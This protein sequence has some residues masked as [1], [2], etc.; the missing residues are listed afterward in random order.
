MK[1]GILFLIAS[2]AICTCGCSHTVQGVQQDVQQNAPIVKAVADQATQGVQQA[3]ATT[4]KIISA[5]VQTFAH[6]TRLALLGT[7]IKAK[8]ITDKDLNSPNNSIHV[9]S[10]PNEVYLKGHVDTTV[11]KRE[12]ESIARGIIAH[13]HAPVVLNDQLIVNP[14]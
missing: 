7:E 13:E 2:A 9:V 5:K 8:I 14:G 1:Y 12:T 6:D 3:G 11:E 10:M 4:D